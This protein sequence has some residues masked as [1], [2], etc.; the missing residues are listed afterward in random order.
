MEY[1]GNSKKWNRIRWDD[2]TIQMIYREWG[3]FYSK[4]DI[5]DKSILFYEK[6]L[7]FNENDTGCLHNKSLALLQTAKS[8]KAI[9]DSTTALDLKRLDCPINLQYSE[10]EFYKNRLEECLSSLHNNSRKF[11][12]GKLKA[13]KEKICVMDTIFDQSLSSKLGT[14]ALEN[15]NTFLKV[16][17]IMRKE[18][19]SVKQMRWKE[20]LDAGEC[21]VES[22]E[23]ESE[24]LLHPREHERRKLSYKVANQ[25]YIGRSWADLVFLSKLRYN[26][27]LLLK[28]TPFSTKE[29]QH[30]I[31]DKFEQVTKFVKMLQNRDPLYNL[32]L[33]VCP[34][35]QLLEKAKQ[36]HLFRIQ[37]QTRRDMFNF[38]KKI[39]ELRKKEELVKL[40]NHV[41]N[42]MSNYT[43]IKTKRVMPWKYEF[44][45]EV[46][47]TIA[48]A[49]LDQLK[50]PDDIMNYE[51]EVRL[52]KI[53]NIVPVKEKESKR[54][55]FGD[56]STF[57]QP[58]AIDFEFVA[59]KRRVSR[60]EKWLEFSKNVIEKTFILHLI[61]QYHLEHGKLE[62]CVH[63][64][65]GHSIF[66][67]VS[68]FNPATE[69][70]FANLK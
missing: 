52:Y 53:L 23:I 1:N 21:D 26:K 22:I 41:E 36:E 48:L 11:E 10:A 3:K 62:D 9:Q 61:S 37:S 16:G 5:I 8:D 56:K 50:I 32:K 54:Y 40:R 57:V 25:K 24:K 49:Y 51:L 60:L 68:E 4:R 44:M 63:D 7:M 47:N 2:E 43:I 55:M 45:C 29:L 39:K 66:N 13:F 19:A 17:E 38:L 30:Q 59:Y 70:Q 35:K 69:E 42:F 46:Y 67:T 64:A 18:A 31:E 12:G 28:Q 6:S 34:D 15:Y 65:K 20:L 33:K 27:T 58:D 14:F